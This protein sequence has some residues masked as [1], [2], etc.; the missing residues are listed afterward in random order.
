MNDPEVPPTARISAAS[1]LLEKGFGKAL[2]T[3]DKSDSNNIF[4]IGVPAKND[5][6]RE[7]LD[8]LTAVNAT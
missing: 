5:T 8:T 7:W 2:Q 3:I 6:A 1:I 4:V